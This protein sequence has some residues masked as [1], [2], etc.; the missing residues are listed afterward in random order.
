MTKELDLF[1][2]E[3]SFRRRTERK[4]RERRSGRCGKECAAPEEEREGWERARDR[5]FGEQE[6]EEEER[7]RRRGEKQHKHRIANCDDLSL[8]EPGF[9]RQTNG[10]QS[11]GRILG[12]T[13]RTPPFWEPSA[14]G[15]QARAAERDQGPGFFAGGLPDEAV[16]CLADGWSG[17]C[18]RSLTRSVAVLVAARVGQRCRPAGGTGADGSGRLM[19]DG[20]WDRC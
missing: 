11:P 17:S 13:T 2:G 7:G 1:W 5:V 15:V 20:G 10:P 8:P 19:A 18:G 12:P 9:G 14:G 3:A 16:P 6:E 4:E